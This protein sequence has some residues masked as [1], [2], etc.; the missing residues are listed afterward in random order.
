M[1]APLVTLP[2]PATHRND[3]RDLQTQDMEIITLATF[4]N[5]E[6]MATD[7]DT[8]TPWALS[9][10][11][12]IFDIALATIA[13]TTLSPLFLVTAFLVWLSSPGPILF[14]EPRVGRNGIGFMRY[15]FRSI[16]L[17][18]D[19]GIKGKESQIVRVT[20]IGSFLRKHKLDKL[21]QLLNV[22]RGDMS[23]LGPASHVRNYEA[24]HMP[25]RPGIITTV[26]LAIHRNKL[27]HAEF[28]KQFTE[29]GNR[30]I[31]GSVNRLHARL[32]WEYIR[33]STLRTDARA[34]WLKAASN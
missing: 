31:R 5:Q 21:P 20:R 13:L 33:N 26:T 25:V 28:V 24:A 32:D 17:G 14:R 9:A 29:R 16:R 23:I 27:S 4:A 19:F 2:S 7:C 22:L 15:K 30:N 8:A 1:N 11:R 10:G 18:E 12:R 3:V 34:L 6:G